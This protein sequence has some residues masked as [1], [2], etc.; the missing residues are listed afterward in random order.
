VRTDRAP[1]PDPHAG[2]DHGVIADPDI[3]LDRHRLGDDRIALLEQRRGVGTRVAMDHDA[4]RQR[5][6][7]ADLDAGASAV[8]HAARV[9]VD[10]VTDGQDV[11]LGTEQDGPR[12]GSAR[13]RRALQNWDG[14]LPK[15]R[16]RYPPC[17]RHASWLTSQNVQIDLSMKRGLWQGLFLQ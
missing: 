5:H 7:V 6:A 12:D 17:I 16:R 3:V 15:D 2:Q 14:R 11:L 1:L 8:D 9:D 13:G 10:I 4:D